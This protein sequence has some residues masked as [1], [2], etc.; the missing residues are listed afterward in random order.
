[1]LS[2]FNRQSPFF[3]H[4]MTNVLN[5]HLN[6]HTDMHAWIC[7]MCICVSPFPFADLNVYDKS[8]L[9]RH[10]LLLLLPVHALHSVFLFPHDIEALTLYGIMDEFSFVQISVFLELCQGDAWILRVRHERWADL[11]SWGVMAL[12]LLM[13]LK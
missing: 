2:I 6:P 3:T 4:N 9:L 7:H 12:D 11:D 8:R 5:L 10:F 1:M 13:E